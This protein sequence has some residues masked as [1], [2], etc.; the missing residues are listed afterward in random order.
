MMIY[1]GGKRISLLAWLKVCVLLTFG[2]LGIRSIREMNAALLC[3]WLW[4]GLKDDKLWKK[5]IEDKYGQ[6]EVDGSVRRLCQLTG[7]RIRQRRLAMGR[8]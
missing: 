2:G 8:Q 7:L 5:I 4:D 1:L 3:K 6:L